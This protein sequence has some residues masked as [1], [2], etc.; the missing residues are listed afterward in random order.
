MLRAAL[1]RAQARGWRATAVLREEARDHAW[2]RALAEE[3]EVAFLPATR[4][5]IDDLLVGDETAILHTHFTMYDLAAALA[6][7]RRPQT[8]V[9]WQVRSFLAQATTARVRSSM[10]RV[11]LTGVSPPSASKSRCRTR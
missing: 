8:H 11:S 9:V 10:T 3:V 1:V 6:A 4:T 2:A 5:A 7:R